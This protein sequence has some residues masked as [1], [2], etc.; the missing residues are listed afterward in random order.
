MS[1]KSIGAVAPANFDLDPAS[2]TAKT[3]FPMAVTLGVQHDLSESWRLLGEYVW[4]QYSRVG[5]VT[6]DGV[7]SRNNG[8]VIKNGAAVQQNWKDQHNIRVAA[9]YLSVPW[10]VRFGYVW[11][12]TVTDP[13]WA[14]AAFTPPGPSHTIT[15]GTGNTFSVGEK[16]MQF[17][18]GVEYTMG[19]GDGTGKAAGATYDAT[20]TSGENDVRSGT[21][22]VAA[23]ALH[24]GLTYAF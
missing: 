22:K 20:Q 5:E 23:Y 24:L 9:E 16:P 18:I 2:A 14:R 7:I 8:T 13:N 4:T 21:Y 1:G 3:T 19:S 15:L 12:S 6:V 10:P 17:D 11:T